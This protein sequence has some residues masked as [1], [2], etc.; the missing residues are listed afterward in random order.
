MSAKPVMSRVLCD[1]LIYVEH[2]P[3][4]VFYY[5]NKAL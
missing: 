4:K 1:Y 5:Y 3:R 2:N